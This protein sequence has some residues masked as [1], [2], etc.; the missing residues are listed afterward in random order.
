MQ[1]KA[2]KIVGRKGE[3]Q[4]LHR[5]LMSSKAEFIAI[6]GR[7]RVGKTYLTKTFFRQQEC[8]FFHVTG[9]NGDRLLTQIQ[10]FITE[11][12]NVFYGGVGLKS[13]KNWE[14]TFELLTKSLEL[15]P[16]DKKIV[17]FFDELPWMVTRRSRLIQT[18]DYYWNRHWVDNKR[19]KLVICGSSASWIIKNIVNN[20]GGLHN[21]ITQLIEL[22]PFDLHGT[23][24]F[25]N[26]I[27]VKLGNKQIL[28]LYMAIG[29]VP[30]YLNQVKQGL[31]AVQN[32]DQ[33][34]FRKD[35]LLFKEFNNLF[36]SL[37]NESGIYIELI[38]T[39]AKHRYGISQVELLRQCVAT[40]AR[41]GRMVG[42]LRDLEDAGF[43]VSFIPYGHK[44]KGMCYRIFD[45]YTLF[46]LSWIEPSA[47]TIQKLELLEN[48][49]ESKTD[50]SSWKAWSGYAFEAVCYKHI[51]NI[52]K[53]LKV[54]AG[55]EV[56]NWRFIPKK[57]QSENGTQID[58]LFD[59]K[60]DAMTICEIKYSKE[61][62]AIDKQYAANLLNKVDTYKKHTGINKQIFIAMI[63]ASGLKPTMYSEEIVS[64]VVTLDD[65]FK[66]QNG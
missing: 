59:R 32:I 62:F 35:G 63:S 25:L 60:D 45:E 36:S 42:R 66:E 50:S 57:A 8:V 58:M 24:E 37:F 44:Q 27:G 26:Y 54:N 14:E 43:I 46:Y 56:G 13:C 16:K 3:Q 51:A 64:N 55:A 49:W 53:A 9:S 28:H 6:Y 41:G 5:T 38:R 29:G 39:I 11:I 1:E 33:L 17:L 65:L 22:K 7:R 18:L 23:K 48:Y 12:G 4:I 61:P 30:H 21:R 31:S 10:R 40:T 15:I 20:K 2:D 47:K 19:L 52:R 34:C